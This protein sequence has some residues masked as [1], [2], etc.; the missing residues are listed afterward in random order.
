[1]THYANMCAMVRDAFPE[2]SLGEVRHACNKIGNYIRRTHQDVHELA[3]SSR[4]FRA[5]PGYFDFEQ[6]EAGGRTIYVRFTVD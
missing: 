4:P 5:K 3:L 2:M 1:M 6:F